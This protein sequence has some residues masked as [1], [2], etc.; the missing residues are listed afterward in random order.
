MRKNGQDSGVDVLTNRY[1]N[2]RSGANLKESKLTAQ[3]VNA[4]SFG[5]LFERDVDGDA[6][7]QPL[8]K[9]GVAIQA[10]GPRN[11]AFV[12]TT[13]NHLYAFDADLSGEAI[14]TG[15]LVPMFWANRS[16]ARR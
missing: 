16:R 15:T 4:Q 2:W 6:F 5:K 14:R 9:T 12:A 7:A 13:N 11:V 3:N 1:D 8:I 10:R